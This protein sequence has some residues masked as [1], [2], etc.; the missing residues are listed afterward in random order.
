MT[1]NVELDELYRDIILDHYRKPRNRGRIDDS[2]ATAEGLN[3]VCGDQV[4]L[5]MHIEP[6]GRIDAIGFQGSGCSISQAAA[7]IMTVS[8]KGKS[9]REASGMVRGVRSML[10]E[11]AR[12]P[13]E[14]GDDIEALQGVAQF[15]AR[16]KCAMLPWTVLEQAL[17]EGPGQDD[18]AKEVST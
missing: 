5:Q 15:P 6:E 8:V 17:Q 3:P 9:V 4:R 12:P 2:N 14:A 7:S 1:R 16:V 11:G 18:P 13:E 10:T